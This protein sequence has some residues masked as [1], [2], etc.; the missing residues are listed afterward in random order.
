[1]DFLADLCRGCPSKQ[2]TGRLSVRF[3][4]TFVAE[5]CFLMLA[6]S[7][8]RLACF[9]IAQSFNSQMNTAC[10]FV[11]PRKHRLLDADRCVP[12][13][14]GSAP[15]LLQVLVK[16]HSRVANDPWLSQK[17]RMTSDIPAFG[18]SWNLHLWETISSLNT[19]LLFRTTRMESKGS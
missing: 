3:K 1:M 7:R 10:F 4:F 19:V 2:T 6:I 5:P 17:G 13:I 15:V 12:G 8:N 11:F 9:K 16:A 18:A 14:E